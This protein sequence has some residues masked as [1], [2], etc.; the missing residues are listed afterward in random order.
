[1]ANRGFR[2]LAAS[3][4]VPA[5]IKVWTWCAKCGQGHGQGSKTARES[6]ETL[7]ASMAPSV[8]LRRSKT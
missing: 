7:R 1:M 4:A 3:M 8:A 2:V 6:F 5:P